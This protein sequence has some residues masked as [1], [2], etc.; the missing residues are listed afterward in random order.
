MEKFE[1][2]PHEREARDRLPPTAGRRQRDFN[3]HEREA[4]DPPLRTPS[5][6]KS[7]FNPHEREARD[8]LCSRC[9]LRLPDFNP[10][11]WIKMK[12]NMQSGSGI[13]SR[14]SRSCGLKFLYTVQSHD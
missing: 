3:P 5:C 14:A 4:R 13:L 7:N 1:I 12:C 8:G 6:Q 2:N 11:V 9:V 10:H